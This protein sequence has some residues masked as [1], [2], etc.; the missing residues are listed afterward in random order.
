MGW[1]ESLRLGLGAETSGIMG[2]AEMWEQ[3]R[4]GEALKAKLG[5]SQSAREPLPAGE[6]D[7]DVLL[8]ADTPIPQPPLSWQ[9][10]KAQEAGSQ[11]SRLWSWAG[12]AFTLRGVTRCHR[13]RERLL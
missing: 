11:V 5:S 10:Y 6:P 1:A 7:S 3:V 8:R 2:G 4:S 12:V 9:P 13:V